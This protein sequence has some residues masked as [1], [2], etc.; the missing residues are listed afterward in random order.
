MAAERLRS[1]GR[2]PRLA[3]SRTPRRI[4]HALSQ[5][6]MSAVPGH[7]THAPVPAPRRMRSGTGCQS[8]PG[9]AAGIR[10]EDVGKGR[11]PSVRYSLFYFCS[12]WL[13]ALLH[14]V[15]A[16]ARQQRPDRALSSLYMRKPGAPTLR[17]D[18]R[19]PPKAQPPK[20]A[21]IWRRGDK[22]EVAS[23]VPLVATA[24]E[25]RVAP[26]DQSRPMKDFPCSGP[27]LAGPAYP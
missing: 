12:Q 4:F 3:R 11:V 6:P 15:L 19:I 13:F 16:T 27:H 22:P 20:A 2:L 8:A 5:A 14:L 24:Q 21:H 7:R 1:D 18:L 25:G 26:R 9:H 17:R 10:S 23:T